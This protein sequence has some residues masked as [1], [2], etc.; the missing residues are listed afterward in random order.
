[1]MISKE[2]EEQRNGRE[3]T[4]LPGQRTGLQFFRHG[5]SDLISGN[6]VLVAQVDPTRFA[7]FFLCRR[8]SNLLREINALE[9]CVHVQRK[10]ANL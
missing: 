8:G 10:V 9:I 4:D 5:H 3:K 6:H 7:G 1:M 2:K